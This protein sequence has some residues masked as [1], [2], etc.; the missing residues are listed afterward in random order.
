MWTTSG[1]GI[2]FLTHEYTHRIIEQLAGIG[3]QVNYRWFDE[4]LADYEGNK[5]LAVANPALAKA[6]IEQEERY[7]AGQ[8]ES[9]GMLKLDQITTGAEWS[10]RMTQG[11]S[12][13][14]YA[15]AA[16]ITAYLIDSRGMESAK[17]VLELVGRHNSFRNAFQ[18]VYGFAPVELGTALSGAFGRC[19]RDAQKAPDGAAFQLH[20]G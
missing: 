13:L 16:R 15:E 20:A 6:K 9:G 12:R 17:Q 1:R 8:F 14:I 11:Q 7:L 19:K 4:G 5:A 3:S 10:D 2:D 18:Q